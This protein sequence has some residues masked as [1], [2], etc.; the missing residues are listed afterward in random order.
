MTTVRRGA[1]SQSNVEALYQDWNG[2]PVLTPTQPGRRSTQGGL[3]MSLG[4]TRRGARP[5]SK[6]SEIHQHWSRPSD[7][8]TVTNRQRTELCRT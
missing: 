3:R 6:V 5:Q 1:R 7:R 2:S 4:G 8:E